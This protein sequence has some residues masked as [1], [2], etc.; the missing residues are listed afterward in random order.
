[1]I[2]LLLIQKK[3][4]THKHSGLLLPSSNR[5]RAGK[6]TV[7]HSADMCRSSASSGRCNTEP[8]CALC[9]C[10]HLLG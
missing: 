6:Q 4:P 8:R 2:L 9:S 7:P 3:N 1:M 5:I 10:L